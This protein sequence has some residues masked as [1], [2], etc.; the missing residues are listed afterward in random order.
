MID[1]VE[2]LEKR[3]EE[4]EAKIEELYKFEEGYQLY[5]HLMSFVGKFEKVLNEMIESEE[6]CEQDKNQFIARLN[7]LTQI[8]IEVSKKKEE[9]NNER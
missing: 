7:A 8:D 9:L 6:T 1:Y 4:L 5:N 3:N 2:E